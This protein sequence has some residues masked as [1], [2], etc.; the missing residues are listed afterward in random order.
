LEYN[1]KSTKRFLTVRKRDFKLETVFLTEMRKLVKS[2]NLEKQKAQFINFRE[3][4]LKV[5]KEHP[6]EKIALDYFNFILWLD[7]K[8][9]N[10][11]YTKLL[12]E[13]A[14]SNKH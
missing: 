10:K 8:I 7:S 13:Q 3:N 1:I 11:S 6:N 5:F 9:Q 14:P 12:M 2:K 4:L